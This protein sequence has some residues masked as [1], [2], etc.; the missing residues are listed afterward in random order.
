M[1]GN[2]DNTLGSCVNL[3]RVRSGW[4][5]YVVHT[6]TSEKTLM[7]INPPMSK[8]MG[9]QLLPLEPWLLL[10]VTVKK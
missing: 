4:Y 8:V 1:E 5:A 2:K 3:W 7:F 9:G 6:G 10:A